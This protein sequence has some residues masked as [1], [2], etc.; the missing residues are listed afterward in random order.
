MSFEEN[1]AMV[2]KKEKIIDMKI[3]FSLFATNKL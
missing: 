3:L 2:I 1:E